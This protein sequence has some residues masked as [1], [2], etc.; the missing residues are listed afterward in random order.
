M[1]SLAGHGYPVVATQE[2]VALEIL[3]SRWLS[4]LT[5]SSTCF[6]IRHDLSS[7]FQ[8]IDKK[9]QPISSIPDWTGALSAR[10][11]VSHLVLGYEYRLSDGCPQSSG[12]Y[13]GNSCKNALRN[14]EIGRHLDVFRPTRSGCLQRLR[15]S[16]GYLDGPGRSFYDV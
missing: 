10:S 6:G 14:P 3:T 15:T 8:V 7:S 9:L 1:R 5:C 16:Q 4:S 2:P 13:L 11:G 12:T